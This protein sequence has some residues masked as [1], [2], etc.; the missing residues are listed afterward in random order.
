MPNWL[1][2]SFLTIADKL[3]FLATFGPMSTWK[4]QISTICSFCSPPNRACSRSVMFYM[5]VN[6]GSVPFL[7]RVC[8][9]SFH[10]CVFTTSHGQCIYHES[11]TNR[12][13]VTTS[14]EFPPLADKKENHWKSQ[15]KMR[16]QNSVQHWTTVERH[17]HSHL[18]RRK[19]R[20][21]IAFR[22]LFFLFVYRWT[23]FGV[24]K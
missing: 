8:G 19:K 17:T 22:F 23:V 18:L 12:E 5:F 6:L 24:V 20:T 16:L 10:F 11:R 14:H 13:L 3:T 2:R 1:N 9:F 21:K 15:K 7:V 4:E